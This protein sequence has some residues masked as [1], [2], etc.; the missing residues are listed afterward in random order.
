MPLRQ[1][2]ILQLIICLAAILLLVLKFVLPG[3]IAAS[4]SGRTMKGYQTEVLQYDSAIGK[5][6]AVSEPDFAT[7][8]DGDTDLPSEQLSCTFNVLYSF[9]NKQNQSF[10]DTIVEVHT[11]SAADTVTTIDKSIYRVGEAIKVFYDPKNPSIFMPEADYRIIVRPEYGN[12]IK[13]FWYIISGIAAVLT[14]VCLIWLF[15]IIRQLKTLE[16]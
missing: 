15:R 9:S 12:N 8:Y 11:K 4:F 1:K 2:L 5:I 10:S 3:L 7:Y 13:K 6:T 16:K 14:I